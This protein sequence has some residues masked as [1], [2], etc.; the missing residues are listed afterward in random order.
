[1]SDTLHVRNVSKETLRK[2]KMAAL[3]AGQSLGA[4]LTEAINGALSMQAPIRI[5]GKV[6]EAEELVYSKPA[7][8]YNPSIVNVAPELERDAVTGELCEPEPKTGPA[9]E[10]KMRSRAKKE[11]SPDEKCRHGYVIGRVC[12]D[13]GGHAHA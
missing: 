4:W 8:K 10:H 7:H 6:G 5:P 12:F 9:V 13:C 11:P 1:M 3:T 2:A